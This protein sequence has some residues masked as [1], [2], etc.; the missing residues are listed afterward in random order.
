MALNDLLQALEEKMQR[1]AE[2][3]RRVEKAHAEGT[4][5]GSHIDALELEVNQYEQIL[6]QAA[7]EL[8]SLDEQLRN[9]K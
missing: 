9:W 4:L 3:E 8:D 5:T 6:D 7:R 2:A 1:C